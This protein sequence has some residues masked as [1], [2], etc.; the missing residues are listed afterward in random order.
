VIYAVLTIAMSV[1][2]FTVGPLRIIGIPIARA[3]AAKFGMPFGPY[4]SFGVIE[5]VGAICLLIGLAVHPL[6]TAA[7][8]VVALLAIE[9]FIA[10][11]RAGEPAVK[12]AL[13]A[14]T[15]SVAL[16]LAVLST[17]R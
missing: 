6:G 8:V 11:L 1:F 17:L 15:T 3:D 4:R 9:A 10:H 7:A 2:M 5:V 16:V 14:L 12:V 13:A